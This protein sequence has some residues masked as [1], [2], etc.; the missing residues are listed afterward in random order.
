MAK[1]ALGRG[2]GALINTRVAAPAP[3]EELGERIQNIA[4][5]CNLIPIACITLCTVC[6][7]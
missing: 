6:K 7:T 1:P 3:V 2:L 4:L 5:A